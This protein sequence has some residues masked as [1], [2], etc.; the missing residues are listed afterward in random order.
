MPV[1]FH[2][3]MDKYITSKRR[4]KLFS[5][6]KSKLMNKKA[7]VAYKAQTKIAG[8]SGKLTSKLEEMKKK[9][10]QPKVEIKQEH[11]DRLVLERGINRDSNDVK[12]PVKEREDDGW[13]EV[14][15]EDLEG[16][17]EE[18]SS[19]EE[20][21]KNLKESLSKIEKK[22]EYEKE[23]LAELS[24]QS[25]KRE[26]EET[27][28]EKVKRLELEEEINVL[29]ERQRIEEDRLSELKT[30]RRKE[31]MDAL[32]GKVMDILFK[33]KPR[34]K[35]D[36]S[37][38]VRDEIR[39]EAR[40]KESSNHKVEKEDI[41]KLPQKD[42][43]ENKKEEPKQEAD[44]EKKKALPKK[45]FFSSFIQIKTTAQMAKEAE[46][47]L[48]REEERALK[49]QLEIK[50]MFQEEIGEVVTNASSEQNVNVMATLFTGEKRTN[51]SEGEQGT[52]LSTLF[53]E[54]AQEVQNEVHTSHDTIDLDQGYK[55]RVVRNQ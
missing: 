16:E 21:R 38:E 12:K 49:D 10:A 37:E 32:R 55:I 28:E 27:E 13:K 45:S 18:L 30:A 20:E 5:N 14:K 17:K 54:E 22:E 47:K 52:N 53:P 3:D 34:V 19:L 43:I 6:F 41:K 2:K 26:M 11:I 50:K 24:E 25:K 8:L 35:K 40:V 9:K 46:E 44:A 39:I 42:A 48:K 36:M 51:I 23:K 29:K 7:S 1:N 31:Q 4:R 33:K 15:L